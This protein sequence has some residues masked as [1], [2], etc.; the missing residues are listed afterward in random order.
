VQIAIISD[1]H[2][3]KGARRLP[4]ECVERLKGADLILHAGDLSVVGVLNHLES[5]GPPIAAIHG[6]VDDAEVRRRI[7][8][9]RVVEAEGVRI[10]MVHDSGSAE[11]RLERLRKRFPDT[12][13]VVYGHSHTPL[14]EQAD[15]GFQIFNPGSPTERRRQPGHTMGAARVSNGAITFELIALD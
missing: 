11:G 9:Q 5:V 10:G 8:A 7:P 12:H 14:H 13:A 15:D 4:D 6:N 2:L 1:T 3:P